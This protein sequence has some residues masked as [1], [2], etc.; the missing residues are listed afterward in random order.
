MFRRPPP[1]ISLRAKWLRVV[2]KAIYVADRLLGRRVY[3]ILTMS[4]RVSK[5]AAWNIADTA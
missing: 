2:G 5:H 4:L 3:Q 1:Y